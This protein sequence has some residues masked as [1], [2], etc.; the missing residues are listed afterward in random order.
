[1]DTPSHTALGELPFVINN[2]GEAYGVGYPRSQAACLR[3]VL[4]VAAH[5]KEK[6]RAW[7]ALAVL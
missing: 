4:G 3:A 2:V 6:G 5:R 1:V 7:W